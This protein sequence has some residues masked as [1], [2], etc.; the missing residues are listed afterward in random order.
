MGWS[1]HLMF[2]GCFFFRVEAHE[3]NFVSLLHENLVFVALVGGEG[4]DKPFQ[5]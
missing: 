3:I 4:S 1:V 5:M 2:V